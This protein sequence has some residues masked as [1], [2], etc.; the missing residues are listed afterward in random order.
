MIKKD[1]LKN[2]FLII[3]TFPILILLSIFIYKDYGISIDEESTRM[4]GLVSLN[5]ISNFFFPNILF[6]FQLANKIPNFQSYPYKEYGVIFEIFLIIVIEILFGIK[7]FSE[8]FYLRHLFTNLLFLSSLICF[9]LISLEIFKNKIFSYMSVIILYSSPRIFA[10]S[11]YNDKDLVFL[12]FI[13]FSI[14]FIFKFLKKIN[15]LNGIYLAFILA[16]TINVR[17]VGI[18]LLLLAIIF[19]VIQILMEREKFYEKFYPFFSFIIL[20]I[21]FLYFFW[22]FLWES[23]I[24]NLVFAIKSFSKYGWGLNVFYLGEFYLDKFLPWHYPY[25]YFFATTS[26]FLSLITLMG[27]CLIIYRFVKRVVKI[28]NSHLYNDIW[29]SHKERSLLFILFSVFTPLFLIYLFDSVIYNGWR[30]LFFVFPSLVIIG[31]YFLEFL[32]KKFRNN[33]ISKIL[34]MFLILIILNNVYNLIK[35]HPF[36]YIYFNKIFESKA[37]DLFEIDYWGVANKQALSEIIAKNSQKEEIIIG[38]AS[39]ANLNLSKKM[40]NKKFQN[41]LIITGQ[42]YDNADFIFNNNYSEVNPLIDDKYSLPENYDKY[43]SFKKGNILIYE[44]YKKND[45]LKK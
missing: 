26:L 14:F 33:K 39:F 27:L 1:H 5:Y 10:D 32:T 23:P 35:L 25:V 31:V 30:H 17:V 13:I 7:E 22:P 43:H 42:E 18:Y 8:I 3:F 16:L 29:R 15:F 11:F 19:I 34:P 44:Y 24:N 9:Y 4:H 2:H 36:Q 41:K 6:D 40:L 45:T 28:D 12:S 37:N 38:V 20:N 21:I